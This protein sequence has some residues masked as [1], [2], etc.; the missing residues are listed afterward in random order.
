MSP[1]LQMRELRL[2]DVRSLIKSYAESKCWGLGSSIH[3]CSCHARWTCQGNRLQLVDRGSPRGMTRT[4]AL[5]STASW[6]PARKQLPWAL[7]LQWRWV[8]GLAGGQ[9]S[10]ILAHL[11][12][13]KEKS[14]HTENFF[15]SVKFHISY[16]LS[17]IWLWPQ[18]TGL[19]SRDM[20][21]HLRSSI[22]KWQK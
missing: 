14:N 5:Y 11:S 9:E 19:M 21:L 16:Y 8:V 12:V 2:R 13:D 1:I 6:N 7:V 18:V 4:P 20:G 3:T 10:P 15:P 22:C 17:L